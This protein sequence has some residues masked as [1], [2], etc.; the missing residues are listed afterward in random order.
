[1]FFSMKILRSAPEPEFILENKGE[2]K[3]IQTGDLQYENFRITTELLKL[4]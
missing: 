4:I 3:R 1:M 2:L